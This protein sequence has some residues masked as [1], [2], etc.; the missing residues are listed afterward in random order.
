V[1]TGENVVSAELK[2]AR[3]EVKVEQGQVYVRLG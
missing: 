1:T 2:V 3:Y